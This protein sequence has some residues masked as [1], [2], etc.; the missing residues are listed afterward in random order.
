MVSNYK[1]PTTNCKLTDCTDMPET[2][3]AKFEIKWLQILDENGKADKALMPKL[4]KEQILK[5]YEHMQVSRTFDDIL[6]KLQ[7]EGRVLT[8]APGKGQE[9]A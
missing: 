4:S 1:L 7:R 3:A 6:F 2:I 8:F 9:A 5:M